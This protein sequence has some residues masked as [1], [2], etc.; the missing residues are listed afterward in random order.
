MY[1]PDL[2]AALLLILVL[3][4]FPFPKSRAIWARIPTPPAIEVAR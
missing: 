2:V 1:M 4:F 3:S